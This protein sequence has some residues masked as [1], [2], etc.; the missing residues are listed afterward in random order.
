MCY[1]EDMDR[2]NKQSRPLENLTIHTV[3]PTTSDYPTGT[4]H[5]VVGVEHNNTQLWLPGDREQSAAEVFRVPP[6]FARNILRYM[7]EYYLNP[8]DQKYRNCHIGAAEMTGVTSEPCA[9]ANDIANH[10]NVVADLAVGQQGVLADLAIGAYHSM[11]GIAPGRAIQT[12]CVGGPMS[13]V[14]HP[15][16][17]EYYKTI[18]NIPAIGLYARHTPRR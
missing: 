2:E 4:Y 9:S 6:D 1:S 10:G 16:N 15:A 8:E 11:V 14:T 3:E 18:E 13:V 7:R 12:D 17:L 5:T